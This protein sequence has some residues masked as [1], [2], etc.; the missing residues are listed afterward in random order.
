[1]KHSIQRR[2]SLST[3]MVS[4]VLLIVTSA[5]AFAQ[6]NQARTPTETVRQF[7]RLMRE[8]KFA[9]AFA[10]T[11]YKPAIEGLSAAEM[12]ELRPDFERMGSVI[13]EKIEVSGEQMSND[14][15][16]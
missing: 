11:I 5:G 7:Y 13:P 3:F 16:T 9:E 14:V 1:M 4:F 15:A 6:T 10:L 8:R 2:L 12:E